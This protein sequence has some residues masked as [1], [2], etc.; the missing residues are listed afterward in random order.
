[1]ATYRNRPAYAGA[2]L[3]A[4]FALARAISTVASLVAAVIVLAIVLQL[5]GANSSNGIVDAIHQAGSWLSAPFHGLFSLN[6]GNLQMTVNW[7]L[8]A[9]VYLFIARLVARVIAR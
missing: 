2:G 7:G 6:N 8:A 9:I 4:R 1:M 5:L 3:G